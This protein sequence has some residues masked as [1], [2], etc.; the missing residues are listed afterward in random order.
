[1]TTWV[2]AQ[3]HSLVSEMLS[4]LNLLFEKQEESMFVT[5][6]AWIPSAFVLCSLVEKMIE[7]H[8]QGHTHKLHLLGDT[9][10]IFKN[11]KGENL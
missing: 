10:I 4:V 5:H 11:R 2:K 1:M 9:F 6:T 7:A 8:T 3:A